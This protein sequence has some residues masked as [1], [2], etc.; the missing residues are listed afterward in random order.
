MQSKPGVA[1]AT[2]KSV[3]DKRKKSKLKNSR[4]YDKVLIQHNKTRE[5]RL[6]AGHFRPVINAIND[7]TSNVSFRGTVCA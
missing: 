5:Q 7:G 4:Q 3:D 1:V 6:L 2:F